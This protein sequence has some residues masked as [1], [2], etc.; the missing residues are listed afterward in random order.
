[1]KETRAFTVVEILIVV[2]IV[3]LLAVLALGRF[4]EIKRE[5]QEYAAWVKLTH[6]KD[7]TFEEWKRL[8]T[9]H[10]L[11]NQEQSAPVIIHAP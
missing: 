11:G 8:K 1:M 10:L 7:I 6:R 4:L 9:A 3:G 2:V 5:P